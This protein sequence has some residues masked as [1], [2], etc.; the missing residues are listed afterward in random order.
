MK[1]LLTNTKG[2]ASSVER[3]IYS[4]SAEG[5]FESNSCADRLKD[6]NLLPEVIRTLKTSHYFKGKS[7]KV[8]YVAT[9]LFKLGVDGKF[10]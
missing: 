4:R 8:I 5:G 2:R 9:A 6:E 1:E 10:N 3:G 7:L